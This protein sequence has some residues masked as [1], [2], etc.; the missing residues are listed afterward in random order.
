MFY[1]LDV[2]RRLRRWRQQIRTRRSNDIT[3]HTIFRY[4]HDIWTITEIH[5]YGFLIIII[6]ILLLTT[7]TI[8]KAWCHRA[9]SH[10]K[11]DVRYGDAKNLVQVRAWHHRLASKTISIATL[12][13]LRYSSKYTYLHG[14]YTACGW[15]HRRCW[16]HQ[17]WVQ[18]QR[19]ASGSCGLCY[20][21]ELHCSWLTGTRRWQTLHEATVHLQY[22]I[23]I[24]YVYM[25]ACKASPKL[26]EVGA[27]LYDKR[28]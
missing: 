16:W 26:G 3:K 13:F 18:A 20:P 12:I 27:T 5:N 1:P 25:C 10:C 7:T 22:T 8:I 2:I 17:T 6:I 15:T 19:Q 11:A 21:L 9:C 28:L 24:Y 23:F 14:I 4:I